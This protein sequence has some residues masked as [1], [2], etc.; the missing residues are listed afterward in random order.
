MAGASP[1]RRF[2]GVL[3]QAHN[4]RFREELNKRK[5]GRYA[6]ALKET[7]YFVLVH[8]HRSP[9]V[10]QVT[11]LRTETIGRRLACAYIWL[12][13]GQSSEVPDREIFKIFSVVKKN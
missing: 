12:Y 7:K 8:G 5:S 3:E 4:L 2:N 6:N 1:G 10:A 11:L 9:Y 13:L